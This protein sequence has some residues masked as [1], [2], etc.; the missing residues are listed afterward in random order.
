MTK[1]EEAFHSKWRK[2]IADTRFICA[3]KGIKPHTREDLC[4]E[5]VLQL[6][7]RCQ[8][9]KNPMVISSKTCALEAVRELGRKVGAKKRKHKETT[10]HEN[11]PTKNNQ[12]LI[13]ARIDGHLN[14]DDWIPYA[15]AARMI[16]I[17]AS[18]LY[19][20]IKEKKL[21]TLACGRHSKSI[22][23]PDME[24]LRATRSKASS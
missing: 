2:V 20:L 3:S 8:R 14:D 24:K 22:F 12:E 1:A 4:Q 6:W 10:L 17:S 23:K 16:G 9:V 7:I 19:R 5:A 13:D 18:M 15:E 11:I 21:R